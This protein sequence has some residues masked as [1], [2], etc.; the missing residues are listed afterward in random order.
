LDE[1]GYFYKSGF[2]FS[3]F[4]IC[5]GGLL[6]HRN[7]IILMVVLKRIYAVFCVLFILSGNAFVFSAEYQG[8]T[9][10][11]FTTEDGLSQNTVMD[12][13]QDSRGYLWLST[14]D[15]LNRFDGYNFRS[16]K[17]R[18]GDDVYITSS[19][20]DKIEEDAFGYLWLLAYGKN[21]VRFNPDKEK[22]ENVPDRTFGSFLVDDVVTLNTGASWLI[23]DG[24]GALRVTTDSLDHSLSYRLFGDNQGL[25]SGGAV[26]KIFADQEGNEWLLTSRGIFMLEAGSDSLVSFFSS[27]QSDAVFQGFFD[28]AEV[29]SELWFGSVSGNVWCYQKQN[30][31]F[32]HLQLPTDFDVVSVSSGDEAS[33]VFVDASRNV[34][35]YDAD[36]TALRL[37]FKGENPYNDQ[38]R[39]AI[40]QASDQSVWVQVSR[41]RVVHFDSKTDAIQVFEVGSIN[42]DG[43]GDPPFMMHEDINGVVWLHPY[44]GGLFYYHPDEGGLERFFSEENGMLPYSDR[45]HSML[46][47][48]QGNLWVG[49][50]SKGL[51]LFVFPGNQFT[52]TE[53]DESPEFISN[54]EVRALFRDSRNYLWVATKAGQ[55]ALYDESDQFLGFFGGDGVLS[56]GVRFNN[57][58]VYTI[59]EDSLGNM[60]LGTKGAGLFRGSVSGE[61]SGLRLQLRQFKHQV[62]DIYSLSHDDVYDLHFDARG[63]FWVATYGGGVNLVEPTP[64]GQ[65]RFIN[66]RNHLTRYPIINCHRVRR[67]VSLS[68]GQLMVGT[69][70]GLL[71]FDLNFKQP[72]DIQFLHHA[73]RPSTSGCLSNNDVHG[74]IET[75]SG[76]VYV[77]TFGGGLNHLLSDADDL[78]Y[79]FENLTVDDGLQTDALLS[80]TEDLN[81]SLWMAT[82]NGITRY[83]PENGSFRN[84]NKTDFFL[85]LSFSEGPVLSMED[86]RMF[87]GTNRGVLNFHPDT[88][89]QNTYVPP[90]VFTEFRLFNKRVQPGED[91]ILPRHIDVMDKITLRHNQNIFSLAFAGMDMKYPEAIRYA[92]RLE[93]FEEDW[94]YLDRQKVVNY[95]NLPAGEFVLK[96]RSTNSDGVWMDNERHLEISIRPSFWVTPMAYVIYIV[97]FAAISWLSIYVLFVIYR[98]RH[99]ISIDEELLAM[100][101]DFFTNISHELRTPLTLISGPLEQVMSHNL[102]DQVRSMLSLVERNTNRMLRLINELLDFVKINNRKLKLCVE[103]ISPGPFVNKILENF[104]FSAQEGTIELSLVD[105]SNEAVIWA[106]AEKLEKIVFN[107][108]SNAFKY[109]GDGKHIRLHLSSDTETVQLEVQDDGLGIKVEDT[110]R[111]FERFE[112]LPG[113]QVGHGMASTGIG[114]AL[115]KELVALHKGNISVR[116]N[117]D[118]GTVFV[119]RLRKGLAHFDDEVIVKESNVVQTADVLTERLQSVEESDLM[120]ADST[121]NVNDA[122]LLLLVEDNAEVRRFIKNILSRTYKVLEAS[123]GEEG[124]KLAVSSL[125]DMVISDLMMPVK[126]GV[127]LL[128]ALRANFDTSHIPFILLTAKDDEESRLEGLEY[129]ADD[130]ITKPFSLSYLLKRIENLLEQRQ[131]LQERFRQFGYTEGHK[132]SLVP[133]M[134]E[135]NSQDEQFLN[136]LKALME[137]NIENSSL[138]VEDLVKEMALSRSV[139]FKKLKALTG[140]APIEYIREMRLQRSVQLIKTGQYNMTQIAYMV[141][142]NDPRYFSKSFRQRFGVTPTEFKNQ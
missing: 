33:L 2:L 42:D 118:K 80:V 49:T 30:K 55:V 60:W 84:F 122:P 139:F 101:L 22:F 134:P 40:F 51:E 25:M 12:M 81:G 69:T 9:W 128:Q 54:N 4:G 141:G 99:R 136:D 23:A 108:L 31:R 28:C 89:T 97:L 142:L 19:R 65:L 123:N 104:R 53:V 32:V 3:V 5:K 27:R 135:V 112:S 68:T 116:N 66:V 120:L 45:F 64:E 16:Y 114:L 109:I 24:K 119:L 63:N 46:S 20:I 10:K 133:E 47:D 18:P 131:L 103:P 76:E 35:H 85:T 1:N 52:L 137:K 71:V 91:Q 50:R 56:R 130:Y 94:V 86:G 6:T 36:Q 48:R 132:I 61:G 127:E 29:G 15:G 126:N 34:F 14:W 44:G 93:G 39:D 75:S 7:K 111:M 11:H 21:V 41:S 8:Y 95:T 62:S 13:V 38:L 107:L 77:A 26:N 140:F 138:V 117:G 72:E 110:Q 43:T 105:E 96:I 87:F 100:K 59:A 129:G 73:Y 115:V 125:P 37:V 58:G 57:K 74:V 67:L 92:A 70:H 83:H 82:E 121:G 124:Y 102:P 17:V 88:L 79:V 78:N 106:D 90:L 98:L 113:K